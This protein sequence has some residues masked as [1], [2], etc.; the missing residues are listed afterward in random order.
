[1]TARKLNRREFL[2][3]ATAAVAG[4]ATASCAAP[5]PEV[6]EKVVKETV[7][8]EKEVEKEVE[9][10]VKET[11]VVEKEVEKEVVVTV[12]VEKAVAEP[13]LLADRV[14]SGEL[15]PIEERIP[16]SPMVVAGRPAIGEYGGEVRMVNTGWNW[17]VGQYGWFCE[18]VLDY[19]DIDFRSI[20]P[21]MLE[22]WEQSDDGKTFTFYMRK[23]MK[24]SDGE[25]MTTDDIKFYFEDFAL[26]EELG[27]ISTAWTLAGETAEVEFL[28]EFSYRVSFVAPYA[29]LAQELTRIITSGQDYIYPSHHMKLF[30]ADYADAE[31]LE[32]RIEAGGQEHWQGLFNHQGQWGVGQWMAHGDIIGFPSMSA[33]WVT[34]KDD[35]TA[36]YVWER[37][38]YYWKSD[39][40]GNQL[41]YLDNVRIEYASGTEIITQKIIQGELD[42]VGPHDVSI[43]RYP[44]YKENEASS[45]YL[46]ADL[47]SCM[48]DRYI[49][50]P[51][52]THV[53]EVL[54]EIVN[55][56]NFVKALSVAID[57]EEINQSL[58]YG[59][60]RMG[61]L[62][63]MPNSKFFKQKY[64]TAWAQYDPDLANDLL[65]EMGL[66]QRDS[67]GFR[68]RPDGETLTYR[69]THSGARVGVTTHEFA[70]M[71]VTFWRDVGIDASAEE[72]D[73]SLYDERMENGQVDCGVWHA[74]RC[75]DLLMPV[76]PNWFIPTGDT[77][78]SQPW[79]DWYEAD[80][81]ERA[82]MEAPP[83]EIQQLL[84]WY[85]EFRITLSES[86]R[87]L[88]FQRIL[89]YLADNPLVI[90]SV[91]ESPAPVLF[92]RNMRNLPRPKAP[93]GW[94]TYGVGAHRPEAFFYEGGERA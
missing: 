32:A 66:D 72:I 13:T 75:T 43:A 4:V 50:L 61:Q 27:W 15:P 79:N 29:I 20:I 12:E 52:H 3:V 86:E 93:I 55:H 92:N 63:P 9:K 25:P 76:E 8:V 17:F 60:A 53:D 58:F 83:E 87:I 91:L 67:R 11:V 39:Q 94:D 54:E 48:T 33:W 36:L 78:M 5:T 35:D 38:P 62:S 90:G 80:E 37:N 57:R 44:L 14:A 51:Q 56:P 24:W 46:V 18:R 49:L 74:D 84:E 45:N 28:D 1:M 41:P 19:S 6:V 85:E 16:L 47:L 65:D 21:N 31:E 30:H 40:A 10:V 88:I 73:E 81:D 26:N 77:V 22:S 59:L 68:L 34:E 2:H 42:F 70:E 7:V 69:I 64:A 23:G 71:V 82:E 89:D